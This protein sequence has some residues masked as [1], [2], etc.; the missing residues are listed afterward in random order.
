MLTYSRMDKKR[1]NTSNFS[2]L[3]NTETCIPQQ[4]PPNLFA[5][6]PDVNRR[7]RQNH[8]RNRMTRQA[9]SDPC[10]RTGIIHCPYGQRVITNDGVSWQT[11]NVFAAF[12]CSFGSE[13]TP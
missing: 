4:T 5:W 3:K 8:H 6:V 2:R 1:S 11:T 9:L 12:D 13:Q 10:R 7:S